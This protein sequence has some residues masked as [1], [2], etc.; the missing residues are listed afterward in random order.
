MKLFWK[1]QKF[2]PMN[3]IYR[4]KLEKAFIGLVANVLQEKR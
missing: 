1:Q 4:R 2:K 3:E